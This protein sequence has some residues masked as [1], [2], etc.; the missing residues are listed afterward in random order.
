MALIALSLLSCTAGCRS[1]DILAVSFV[2]RAAFSHAELTQGYTKLRGLSVVGDLT[3]YREFPFAAVSFRPSAT[4][5]FGIVRVT[6]LGE[7]ED[8]I[9]RGAN[10]V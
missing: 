8:G 10:V 7:S 1:F 5:S 2:I 6:R 4:P 9:S 3:R